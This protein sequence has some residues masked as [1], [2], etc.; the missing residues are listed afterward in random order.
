MVTETVPAA[1][2]S[3]YEVKDAGSAW[4]LFCKV[5]GKGWALKKSS[6]APGNVLHLLGAADMNTRA[7][8]VLSV[9]REEDARLIAAAPALLEALKNVLPSIGDDVLLAEARAAIQLA[10]GAAAEGKEGA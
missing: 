3:K 4:H 2:P 1:L 8:F 10:E 5:C 7:P 9:E 6:T